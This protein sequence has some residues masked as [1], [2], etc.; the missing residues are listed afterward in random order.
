[1]KGLNDL[2][3]TEY[4]KR[5]GKKDWKYVWTNFKISCQEVYYKYL[6]DWWRD[7]IYHCYTQTKS[8]IRWLPI[9][10]KDRN[11][12]HWFI[13]E[14]LKHKIRFQREYITKHDRHTTAQEDGRNMRIAEVLIDRLQKCEYVDKDWEEHYK[15]WPSRWRCEDIEKELNRPYKPG[16]REDVLRIGAREKYMK[17]QDYEY[18]FRHLKKH[19]EKWWD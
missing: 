5:T 14:I 15:Q 1:M 9:L 11:W 12:D 17:N 16:E 18:L 8:I 2:A 7:P 19:I 4:A 6:I 13:L 3:A 10:W